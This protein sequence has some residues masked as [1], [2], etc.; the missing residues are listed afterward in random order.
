MSEVSDIDQTIWEEYKD[1]G[2]VVW[3]IGPDD[4]FETLVNYQAQYGITFP[5]LFDELGAVHELYN[6][7]RAFQGTIYPDEWII[8]A[9]GKVVY[10]SAGYDYAEMKAVVE[11]ELGLAN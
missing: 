10:L 9:D 5:I 6:Q 1:Q 2:L 3:G 11:E 8:G 7:Q 4:D